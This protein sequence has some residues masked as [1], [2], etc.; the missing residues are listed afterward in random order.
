[1]VTVSASTVIFFNFKK[2]KVKAMDSP[3]PEEARTHIHLAPLSLS[4]PFFSSLFSLCQYRRTGPFHPRY[5]ATN[6]PGDAQPASTIS[7]ASCRA[8]AR[9]SALASCE[10][11]V[12]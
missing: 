12:Q 4:L 8:T 11:S 1:M 6:A 5:F 3:T 2:K 9:A 10:E 7:A